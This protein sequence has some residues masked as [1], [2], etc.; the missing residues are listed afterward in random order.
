MKEIDLKKAAAMSESDGGGKVYRYDQSI[1][2]IKLNKE[3]KFKAR[4]W[5]DTEYD[6]IDQIL[7]DMNL[8]RY[9][10]FKQSNQK[11]AKAFNPSTLEELIKQ[12]NQIVNSANSYNNNSKK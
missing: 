4:E 1:D 2:F 6:I 10:E 8:L 5:I 9:T 12:T 11:V 3:T 7:I